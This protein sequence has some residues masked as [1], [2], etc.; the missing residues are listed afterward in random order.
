MVTSRE[1][2]SKAKM[3]DVIQRMP[4]DATIDDA[5]YRLG[6]LKAVAEGIESA[7]KGRLFDH[8]QVFDEL[9]NDHAEHPNSVDGAG[10]KGSARTKGTDRRIRAQ[11]G[12]G[13]RQKTKGRRQ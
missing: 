4:E 5:I 2:R 11:N 12:T 7:E 10:K 9:L 6:L 8:D 13:V 1:L 3:L